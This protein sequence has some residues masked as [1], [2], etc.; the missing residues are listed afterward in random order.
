MTIDDDN[1]LR[2]TNSREVAPI[3]GGQTW[4]SCVFSSCWQAADVF[5]ALDESK[6][7]NMVDHSSL[8]LKILDIPVACFD[9][10]RRKAAGSYGKVD[11]DQTEDLII[12]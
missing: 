10:S 2:D 4:N 7:T 5:E 6:T 3:C 11:V 9:S 12:I 8:E 1:I